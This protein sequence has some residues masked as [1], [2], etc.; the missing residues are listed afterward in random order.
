L[1]LPTTISA[2]II[3]Y[4]IQILYYIKNMNKHYV[5]SYT[6]IEQCNTSVIIILD[7]ISTSWLFSNVIHY[8]TVCSSP[9]LSLWDF[10][11]ARYWKMQK[12][13]ILILSS[14]W[15]LIKFA[16]N[17]ALDFCLH[18]ILILKAH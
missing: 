4:Y 1:I 8:S 15:N 2:S 7:Y 13:E 14:F 9:T 10:L 6:Y 5:I 3:Y 18:F 12:K 11:R 17:F 16:S